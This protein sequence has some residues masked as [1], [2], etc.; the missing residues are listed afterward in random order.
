MENKKC[1]LLDLFKNN[2]KVYV[3]AVIGDE[4]LYRYNNKNNKIEYFSNSK[5]IWKE[6][7]NGFGWLSRQYFTEYIEPTYTI[8]YVIK[9]PDKVFVIKGKGHDL[10]YRSAG[11]KLYTN[12]IGNDWTRSTLSYNTIV[13]AEFV[14][15]KGE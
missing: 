7:S 5:K 13:E 1:T 14:E 2:M 11:K 3:L 12:I 9:N 8:E 6:T 10:L 4:S 15:Y